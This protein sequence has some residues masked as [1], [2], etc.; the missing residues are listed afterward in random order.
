MLLLLPASSSAPS[1][2]L[3]LSLSPHAL[4]GHL[5]HY[6]TDEEPQHFNI[7][8]HRFNCPGSQGRTKCQAVAETFKTTQIELL[9]SD[10]LDSVAGF[11]H[12]F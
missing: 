4:L 8:G 9:H 12:E 10:I 1:L 7:L 11:N 5:S 3:S 2:S 6:N